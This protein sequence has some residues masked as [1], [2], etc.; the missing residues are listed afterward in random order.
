MLTILAALALRLANPNDVAVDATLQCGGESR[1][2]RLA[3]REVRDFDSC[4]PV[5]AALPLLAFSTTHEDGR[6]WLVEDRQSCLSSTS[7][8]GSAAMAVP[9]FA[10]RNGEANA[11]VQPVDGAT[12]TWTVEGA[13]ITDGG[14]TNRVNLRL[15]SESMVKLSVAITTSACTTTAS[16]VISVRE[17][18]E[19]RELVVPAS[20]EANQP[21][22]VRWSYAPGRE[23]ASQ[24]LLGSAFVQPVV[25]HAQQRSHTF[26]PATAGARTVE[27]RASYANSILVASP[28]R[29]R[30]SSGTVVAASECPSARVTRN[31]DI[32]GCSVAEPLLDAPEDVAAGE[33][34]GVSTA[35]ENGDEVEWIAENGTIRSTSPFGESAVV[36]AGPSGKVVVTARVQRAGGCIA[37]A[38]AEVPI[39]VAA[40]QCSRAPQVAVTLLGQDCNTV[41]VLATFTGTPPFVGEWADGT[42]FRTSS[43]TLVHQFRGAGTFTMRKFRDASCYGNVTAAPTLARLQPRALLSGSNSCSVGKLTA[44]LEGVPPFS[45]AWSDGQTFTTSES[46]IERTVGPGTWSIASLTDSVCNVPSSSTAWTVPAPPQATITAVPWCPSNSLPTF[47][48]KITGG[49]LPYVVYWSDGVVTRSDANG[50][51]WRTFPETRDPVKTYDMVR[52]TANGCEAELVGNVTATVLFRESGWLGYGGSTHCVATDVTKQLLSVPSTPGALVTWKFTNQDVKI[53]SG[54]NTS[55]L[56][57]RAEKALKSDVVIET[58]YPDGLC[59]RVSAPYSVEFRG[60]SNVKAVQVEPSTIPRYGSAQFIMALEGTPETLS[61]QAARGRVSLIDCCRGAYHDTVG[62]PG[63]VP[64]T[65]KWSDPCLGPRETTVMVTITP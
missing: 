15:G 59:R 27:L 17:P 39:I 24:I 34:F 20:A 12:Y 9:L 5:S 6:E 56:T 3:A 48:P 40:A 11:Y 10:C 57:F 53:V 41:R 7:A 35:V 52:V 8:C 28:K 14:G 38:S 36:Q 58:S 62:T 26:T 54:Q 64:I 19:V 49:M 51:L 42:A 43:N 1:L 21:V 30:A 22:T 45:G 46:T 31:I 33:V 37:A 50:Y 18:I 23:P 29:R 60:P 16:G 55:Q 32:R 2:V 47:S 63:Q 61:V 4:T 65:V 25:L 44:K 13:T